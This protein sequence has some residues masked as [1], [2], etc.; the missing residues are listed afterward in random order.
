MPAC[1]STRALTRG[2]LPGLLTAAVVALPGAGQTADERYRPLDGP[3]LDV[4]DADRVDGPDLN[5]TDRFGEG[6]RARIERDRLNR[7]SYAEERELERSRSDTFGPGEGSWEITLAGGGSSDR[8]F[9]N[10]V[11]SATVDA[12][13]YFSELLAGGVRQSVTA[14]GNEDN[15]SWNGATS[16][17]GQLHFGETRLRPF[18][19]LEVGYLYGDDVN[20]TGFGGPEAG[21][22][23]YVKDEA[24][25]F[26]R[27][28]YQFLFES[29]DDVEDNFDD[30]RFV[31]TV[32]V[33]FTF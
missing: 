32:G 1:F 18:V 24:F 20:D 9:D 12:S 6:D 8:N 28:N 13:Y 5:T 2:L 27:A 33:G 21:L 16:V 10:N 31:Y 17:F 11:L 4:N 22:K 30:G 23:Y 26:A 15:S 29:G 25:L 19:G 14:S 7:S 3:G